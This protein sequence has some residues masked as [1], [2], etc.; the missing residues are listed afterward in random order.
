MFLSAM[1][2][3]QSC[4]DD[5]VEP[6]YQPK[7]VIIFENGTSDTIRLNLLQPSSISGEYTSAMDIKLAKNQI[8]AFPDKGEP[9]VLVLL[10]SALPEDFKLIVTKKAKSI[11]Y[12]NFK[13]DSLP[14]SV[15]SVMN[16]NS[17]VKATRILDGNSFDA[18]CYTFIDKDFE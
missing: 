1:L 16:L 6:E 8:N 15:H 4:L 5:K 2:L 18:L 10:K 12:S 13:F 7:N 9:D 11:E 14:E 17:W 3:V